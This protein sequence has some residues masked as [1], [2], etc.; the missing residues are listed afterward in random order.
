MGSSPDGFSRLLSLLVISFLGVLLRF[1]IPNKM[2][3]IGF[4]QVI[5]SCL[6][7]SLLYKAVVEMPGA[8]GG[9]LLFRYAAIALLFSFFLAACFFSVLKITGF[10]AALREQHTLA[11]MFPSLAPGLTSLPFVEVVVASIPPGAIGAGHVGL[12]DLGVKVF[13]LFLLYLAA[14][15][16]SSRTA[17]RG[18]TPLRSWHHGRRSAAG[19]A[20]VVDGSLGGSGHG[21]LLELL[22]GYFREPVSVASLLAFG[23]LTLGPV[24]LRDQGVWGEA[25]GRLATCCTPSIFLL[26]GVKLERPQSRHAGLFAL[27]VA[28]SGFAFL[29]VWVLNGVLGLGRAE[30]MLWL[31]F[32]NSAVSFWPY[33]HIVGVTQREEKA[34]LGHLRGRLLALERQFAQRTSDCPSEAGNATRGGASKAGHSNQNEPRGADIVK[35]LRDLRQ[36]VEGHPGELSEALQMC[37]DRLAEDPEVVE[38]LDLPALG[39]A[40]LTFDLPLAVMTVTV[41]SIW[42]VTLL[43]AM[44]LTPEAFWRTDY[45]IPAV[46]A[47]F[48]L[49]GTSELFRRRCDKN[50][51][52]RSSIMS[53]SMTALEAEENLPRR[54][55]IGSTASRVGS[56]GG[57]G[58]KR[59]GESTSGLGEV[60]DIADERSTDAINACTSA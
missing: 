56:D 48:V 50:R 39:E 13:V 46:G 49:I 54:V 29:F 55:S 12:A 14:V 44:S 58:G 4:Q 60:V 45:S 53:K 22:R 37:R 10:P 7:P 36:H 24:R 8:D 27:M 28:R 25:V 26:I 33:T 31:F 43:A 16:L 47:G 38:S 6:L 23:L 52:R 17:R 15:A 3:V 59:S 20:D 21:T 57:D 9:A 42:T 2:H 41:S 1:K 40:L 32:C 51:G 35:T 5:L 11:M 19:A 18:A 30:L 34:C